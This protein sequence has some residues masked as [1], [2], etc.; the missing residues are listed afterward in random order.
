MNGQTA[1]TRIDPGPSPWS[2]QTI[3][4]DGIVLS[5]EILLERPVTI[6]GELGTFSGDERVYTL[7]TSAPPLG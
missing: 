4:R 1:H 5:D 6:S 7:L 2:G 3:L